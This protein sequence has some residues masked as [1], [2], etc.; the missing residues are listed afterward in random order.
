M[1]K[2]SSPKSC[3]KILDIAV[4]RDDET[5]C[6]PS[7]DS[8][9]KPFPFHARALFSTSPAFIFLLVGQ[10]T[11][12]RCVQ[13]SSENP[14]KSGNDK[15]HGRS[16]K[17]TLVIMRAPVSL[18]VAGTESISLG[19][20]VTLARCTALLFFQVAHSQ[21]IAMRNPTRGRT[22]VLRR[23]SA[24]DIISKRQRNVGAG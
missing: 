3:K 19:N 10:I 21:Q 4:C 9:L 15:F 18:F 16:V 24:R 7:F 23:F 17:I 5:T 14:K 12:S 2:R 6:F 13:V 11:D 1:P 20:D 22:Y 8:D